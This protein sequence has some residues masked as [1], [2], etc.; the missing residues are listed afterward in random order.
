MSLLFTAVSRQNLMLYYIMLLSLFQYLV[1][2]IKK[3][4][5][6]MVV[7]LDIALHA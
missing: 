5:C 6:Q 4:D 1:V 7:L 2:L 3:I